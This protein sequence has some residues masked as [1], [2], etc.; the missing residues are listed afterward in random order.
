[1]S[2]HPELFHP[3]PHDVPRPVVAYVVDLQRGGG[4]PPHSHPRAQLIAIV[5][6]SIAVTT[7]DGTFVV[8]AERALWIPADVVHETR[9]LASTR[10][11]TLYVAQDAAP[12]LPTVTTVVQVS[13][14]MRC[15]VDAFIG[16]PRDYDQHGADGRLI[17]VLLDQVANSTALPLSLPMPRA[18]TLRHLADQILAAP[19]DPR[20]MR[21]WAQLLGL[22]PRTLERHFKKDTGITLRK[23]R[24]QAKLFKALDMLSTGCPVGTISDELGFEGPSAFI[25]MF[26][27]AFG[28][29]PGRYLDS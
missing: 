15:L 6:G 25:A 8:P 9:H 26:K 16:R 18:P 7:H 19:D 24:Q 12:G 20:G 21:E 23:F 27:A 1:M 28:V 29:T 11:R 3:P 22:S 14:L 4:L 13:P 10:L 2:I 5:S 17:A